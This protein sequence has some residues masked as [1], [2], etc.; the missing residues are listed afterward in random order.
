MLIYLQAV[1]K[2]DPE[3]QKQRRAEQ[4]RRFRQMKAKHMEEKV[5]RLALFPRF[6][7]LIFFLFFYI[8]FFSVNVVQLARD[9]ERLQE[10]VFALNLLKEEDDEEHQV[11]ITKTI[12][13]DEQ[14]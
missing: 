7:G 6:S 9:Q 3:T 10:L 12:Q 4:A 5:P 1:N 11:N 14:S 8:V 13:I 2:V